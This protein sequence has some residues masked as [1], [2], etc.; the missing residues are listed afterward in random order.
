MY[1]LYWRNKFL[2]LDAASVK[3]MVTRLR[4][5]ASQLEAM[6]NDGIVLEGGQEDDYARLVTSDPTVAA[7]Y[8]MEQEDAGVCS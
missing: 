3:D 4:E 5:A 8:G 7:K 1:V 2:T 6:L